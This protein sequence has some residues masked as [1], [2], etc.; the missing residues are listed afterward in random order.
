MTAE[1]T[2]ENASQA[3]AR[4]LMDTGVF[5]RNLEKLENETVGLLTGYATHPDAFEEERR[6]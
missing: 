4:V 5:L 3:R 1:K 6:R 2:V